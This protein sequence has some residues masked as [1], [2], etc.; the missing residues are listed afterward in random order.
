M[1]KSPMKDPLTSFEKQTA[2]SP[3]KVAPKQNSPLAKASYQSLSKEAPF[4]DS[5][6]KQGG[7]RGEP[8]VL[9]KPLFS[10]NSSKMMESIDAADKN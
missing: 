9:V 1:K 8:A 10:T 4:A 5:N 6:K 3:R 7:D 2:D